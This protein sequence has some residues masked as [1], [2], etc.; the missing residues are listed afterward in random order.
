MLIEMMIS[1][2]IMVII[3]GL[4]KLF[5]A[6]SAVAMGIAAALMVPAVSIFAVALLHVAFWIIASAGEAA[7]DQRHAKIYGRSYRRRFAKSTADVSKTTQRDLISRGLAPVETVK[8]TWCPEKGLEA[9]HF[10]ESAFLRTL[11]SDLRAALDEEARCRWDEITSGLPDSFVELFDGKLTI[12]VPG[13]GAARLDADELHAAMR[14]QIL[15]ALAEMPPGVDVCIVQ[16]LTGIDAYFVGD[17]VTP[18]SWQARREGVRSAVVSSA[19]NAY[20]DCHHAL[21]EK[22]PEQMRSLALPRLRVSRSGDLVVR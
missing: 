10:I 20:A 6:G 14:A 3:A 9:L 11:P 8:L 5:A 7:M 21:L 18:P 16:N 19:K 4:L 17:E 12:I 2:V 22:S 15:P 13:Q 1:A